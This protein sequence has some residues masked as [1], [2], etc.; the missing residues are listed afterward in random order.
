[1]LLPQFLVEEVPNSYYLLNNCWLNRLLYI[2]RS[3]CS[4]RDWRAVCGALTF[5]IQLICLVPNFLLKKTSACP[6]AAEDLGILLQLAGLL[7]KGFS[8]ELCKRVPD[9]AKRLLLLLFFISKKDIQLTLGS[10][11][12]QGLSFG[13]WISHKGPLHTLSLKTEWLISF[14]LQS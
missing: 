7:L 9:T 6:K 10:D 1:M 14:S 2:I 13:L 5:V 3:F 11:L 12:G 4:L 8:A